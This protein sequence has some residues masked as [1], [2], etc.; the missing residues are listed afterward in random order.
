M[1]FSSFTDNVAEIDIP[2]EDADSV[3]VDS[4]RR[5][6]GPVSDLDDGERFDGYLAKHFRFLSRSGWQKRIDNG[7]VLVNTRP[8]K[9]SA[10]LKSG[11]LIVMH[12][13][14]VAEP[15]VD[16]NIRVIWQDGP[17]MGVFKPGNLPMHENGP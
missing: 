8:L 6:G 14:P 16:R 10:K 12:S 13:P 3:G 11:D 2:A 4:W 9:C 1:E 5:I 17:V 7:L 15:E